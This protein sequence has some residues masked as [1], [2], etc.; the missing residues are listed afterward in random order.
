MAQYYSKINKTFINIIRLCLAHTIVVIVNSQM[1]IWNNLKNANILKPITRHFL[2]MKKEPQA[3]EKYKS[4]VLN[5]RM[6][7]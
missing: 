2:E 1:H 4:L 7:N 6:K 3:D 5:D